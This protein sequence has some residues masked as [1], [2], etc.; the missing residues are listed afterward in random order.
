MIAI[1]GLIGSGKSLVAD[2]VRAEGFSVINADILAHELYKTNLS[3]QKEIRQA[4]GY[5]SINKNGINRIYMADLVFNN[6]EKLKLL[7]SII[8]PILQKE[9]ENI[10]PYFVEAAVLY[11]WEEFAK[12]TEAIWVVEASEETRR[13]RLLKRGL[14]ENDITNRIKSQEKVDYTNLNKNIIKID[15]NSSPEFCIDFTQRIVKE[16][17][18]F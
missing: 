8:H 3:L 7:E 6:C 1:T 16:I 11:K 2:V 17:Q 14:N 9:I 13:A 18:H 10:N 4:F 5:E 12:K 15:N